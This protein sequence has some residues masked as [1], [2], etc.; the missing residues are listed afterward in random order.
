VPKAQAKTTWR[1]NHE[2]LAAYRARPSQM[3]RL[4]GYNV[5]PAFSLAAIIEKLRTITERKV[6][7]LVLCAAAFAGIA[8]TAQTLAGTK[9][10]V[11]ARV[12]ALFVFV[13]GYEVI[14]PTIQGDQQPA[15]RCAASDMLH[16][17]CTHGLQ[18]SASVLLCIQTG[19]QPFAELQCQ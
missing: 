7:R 15:E 3:A 8:R 16:A 9:L 11:E 17:G 10:M 6:R 12:R 4:H 2:H 5:L 1:R 13:H 19:A 18:R 14:C